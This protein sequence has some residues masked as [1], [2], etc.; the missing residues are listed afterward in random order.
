MNTILI[1]KG[2]ELKMPAIGSVW[3]DDNGV[4]AVVDSYKDGGFLAQIDDDTFEIVP[5]YM[6]DKFINTVTCLGDL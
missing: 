6:V 1:G 5:F 4:I 2:Y 3:M